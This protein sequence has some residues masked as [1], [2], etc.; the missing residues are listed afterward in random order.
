MR[1]L[2]LAALAL[3]L[4]AG[5]AAAQPDLD[6]ELQVRAALGDIPT[7]EAAEPAG[8]WNVEQRR[9]VHHETGNDTVVEFDLPAGSRGNTPS[10]DCNFMQEG[11]NGGIRFTIPA[12]EPTGDV[13][14]RVVAH[15][16]NEPAIA[17]ALEVPEDV[18]GSVLAIVYSATGA[19]VTAAMEEPPDSPLPC[20]DT[21]GCVLHYYEGTPEDPAPATLWFSILPPGSVAEPTPV[22]TTV[23]VP[24]PSEAGSWWLPLAVGLVLGFLVWAMLVQRGVVQRRSRKQVVTTAAH[25]EMA[26]EGKATLEARKRTL[27]AALKELE[28][29]KMNGEVD[30]A[31]Y[32]RLKAEYKKETVSVM[33]ALE[34]AE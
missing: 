6:A 33:R 5:T 15:I 26:R 28:V 17:F 19:P 30:T 21:V 3:L 27:M 22:T 16:P 24:G 23:T 9:T 1:V 18:R 20:A 14:P 8:T 12:T 13:T 11:T 25:V 34:Q 10:C 2:P 4:A 32:D 29:A 31:A 7:T